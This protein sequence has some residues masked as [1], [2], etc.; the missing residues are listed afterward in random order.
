MTPIF[1]YLQFQLP[2][3]RVFRLTNRPTSEQTESPKW[4]YI[5]D[6]VTLIEV[7]VATLLLVAGPD[8]GR[9]TGPNRCTT[10]RLIGKDKSPS[11]W[12]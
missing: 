4:G 12:W 3:A 9:E 2:R 8:S 10:R 5:F 7:G 6:F 1:H 11:R